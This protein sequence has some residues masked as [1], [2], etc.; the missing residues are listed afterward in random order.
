MKKIVVAL[1][2]FAFVSANAQTVDEVIQKYSAAMGSLEGFNKITSAK[3]TGSVAIQGMDFPVTTQ[4]LNGKGMRTDVDVMGKTV[5]NTYGFGKAW[6]INPYDGAE[7]ATEVTGNDLIAFKT[8]ASLANNLMDYKNR[9]HKVE[10]AGEETIEGVKTFKIKLTNNEDNKDSWYYITASDHMLLKTV[11]KRTMAGD[12]VEVE[13]FYSNF[14]EFNG[15][16]FALMIS[17]QAGGNVIQQIS[18][19][20]IELNVPVDET[21]FKM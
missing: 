12:E 1:L 16:K 20:N 2:C 15:I 3:M 7:I 13:T 10:L 17:Q 21:I 4:I 8:Q 14:K 6:K 5:T 19:S 18:W 9:G 11:S